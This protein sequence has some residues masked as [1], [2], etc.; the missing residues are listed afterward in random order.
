MMRTLR[1][2]LDNVKFEHTIFALPFAYLGMALA[3]GGL[4]TWGQASWVTLAMAGARTLAMS[5]N[6]VIDAESDARNPR[7]AGRPI[8]RGLLSGRSVWLLAA[9]SL[10]VMLISAWQLNPLCLALS[11][12]AI[13]VLV[14]YPYTKR[15]TW[16]SHA[17]LGLADGIAPVGG[18]IAVTGSFAPEAILLGGVVAAWVGGFDLIYA[19]QDVDFDRREG[20]YSVP[21]RFGIPAALTLSVWT[22]VA[23]AALLAAV[24]W[25]MGLS[26]PFWAGWLIT[27]G[28]LVY[29]HRLV[30][31]D[32][33]SRLDVAF[34][35][36]NGYI[37]VVVFVFTLASLYVW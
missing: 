19:C 16:L 18:W 15:F 9:A 12:L 22:H 21:A 33:L 20:L 5:L 35:N 7:T 4:P 36:I 30:K 11:P 1:I 3:A 10:V 27:C 25:L 26:W 14:V 23:G 2:L 32:D 13:I 37:A 17:V 24:G 28:L 29:E 34:F 31:P 6:R 8:P